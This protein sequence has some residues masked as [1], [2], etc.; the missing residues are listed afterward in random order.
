M[1]YSKKFNIFEIFF[2]IAQTYAQQDKNLANF[3]TITPL[4]SHN[5]R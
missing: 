5:F 1:K 3:I 2:G 4:F